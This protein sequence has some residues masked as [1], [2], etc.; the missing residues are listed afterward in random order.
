MAFF[1]PAIPELVHGLCHSLPLDAC[2]TEAIRPALQPSRRAFPLFPALLADSLQ[3]KQPRSRRTGRELDHR[4]HSM[5]IRRKPPMLRRPPGRPARRR[6]ASPVP[7][8]G[9]CRTDPPDRHH[10]PCRNRQEPFPDPA[11]SFKFLERR[12]S[13]HASVANGR[14]GSGQG[15]SAAKTGTRRSGGPP[16]QPS[17]GS[18][19]RRRAGAGSREEDSRRVSRWLKRSYSQ[20]L[21]PGTGGGPGAEAGGSK[22]GNRACQASRPARP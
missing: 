9:G 22:G 18:R 13:S 14:R 5:P 1:A 3:D 15:E 17:A 12:R 19:A 21:A 7:S 6:S 11:G 10:P 8:R 20:R 4:S 16:P 2:R